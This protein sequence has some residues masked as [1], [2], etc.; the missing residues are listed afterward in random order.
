MN[1]HAQPFTEVLRSAASLAQ[2]GSISGSL[3]AHGYSKIVG[4]V[5]ASASGDAASAVMIEESADFGSNWEN[6]GTC[7]AL[8]ADSASTFSASLHGNAVKVTIKLGLT[9]TGSVFRT[10]WYLRPI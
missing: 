6:T 3:V 10:A 4:I 8:T 9:D 2:A 1:I 7:S 5:Y